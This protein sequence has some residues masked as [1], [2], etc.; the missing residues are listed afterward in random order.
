M[1]RC[2]I[3]Q[4]KMTFSLIKS[5]QEYNELV[6]GVRPNQF[7]QSWEWG[8]FQA[9]VG[10]KVWRFKIEREGELMMI[11]QAFG[12]TLPYGL[13]Y[14]YLPRGPLV[15][16]AGQNHIRECLSVFIHEISRLSEKLV[17]I[18][19][20]STGI[21]YRKFG[22]QKIKEIQ[23]SYSLLLSLDKSEEDLL[24]EMHQKTRY[25]I[26]I[27]IKHG[28]KIRPMAEG[29]FDK[30]WS[31]V[32]ETTARD[33]FRSHPRDYYKIMLDSLGEMAQV[34]LAEY[35]GRIIAAN[36]MIFWGDQAIYLHG[37]SSHI[38]KNV[39][40]PYLLHW[41]MIK[42][43]KGQGKE[44]YDFWGIAPEDQPNHPWVG[45]T[46]FKKGFAGTKVSYPGTFD[47]AQNKI[48]YLLYRLKKKR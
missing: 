21:D 29:E 26:R 48:W 25:N 8:E 39:M 19:A 43:A 28:V 14:I 27:A 37:A 24:K 10:R 16:V 11:G 13:T 2:V 41:E 30:F 9:R 7:L 46:R 15:T 38:N 12:H 6:G 42:K 20:E 45:I 3:Y 5:K 17:F 35:R 33:R 32:Q 22:W 36:L 40:A 23:P 34:W 31:L 1:K 18:R 4:N 44:H 47:L